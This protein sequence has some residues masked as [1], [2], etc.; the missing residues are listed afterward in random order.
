MKP[1]WDL[2]V[3]DGVQAFSLCPSRSNRLAFASQK[4]SVGIIDVESSAL[5][6]QTYQGH[7]AIVSDS[8]CW[9][10]GSDCLFLSPS[11]DCTVR[12]WDTRV[13]KTARIFKSED[14]I[15][16]LAIQGSN[17][18][19]GSVGKIAVWDLDGSAQEPINEH[20]PWGKRILSLLF[21]EKLNFLFSA[22]EDVVSIVNPKAEPDDQLIE[23]IHAFCPVSKMGFFGIYNQFYWTMSNMGSE[24]SLWNLDPEVP[25][26]CVFRFTGDT[27]RAQLSEI[28]GLP[29]FIVIQLQYVDFHLYLYAA[30]ADPME[31]LVLFEIFETKIEYKGA[32]DVGGSLSACE[33]FS[34]NDSTFLLTGTDG[35]KVK[36][37]EEKKLNE[38]IA[39]LHLT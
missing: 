37:F 18:Y 6:S 13:G 9:V 4:N 23:G 38:A 16:S 10:P 32:L 20:I 14:A 1:V 36:L 2:R 31:K 15:Y 25:N 30:A 5:S 34:V 35:G 7:T 21:H 19:A 11:E 26:Y 3:P 28:S 33:K 12:L 8:L 27:L 17:I 29:I 22:C 39:G 24:L